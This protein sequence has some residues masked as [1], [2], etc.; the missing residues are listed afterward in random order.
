MAYVTEGGYPLSASI[1][2]SSISFNML[3]CLPPETLRQILQYLTYQDV[4]NLENIEQFEHIINRYKVFLPR[5]PKQFEI[6]CDESRLIY[7]FNS[8]DKTLLIPTMST[9]VVNDMIRCYSIET[10]KLHNINDTKHMVMMIDEIFPQMIKYRQKNIISLSLVGINVPKEKSDIWR[11]VFSCILKKDC[12]TLTFD[13]VTLS[14]IFDHQIFN[15]CKNIINV[16]WIITDSEE[17]EKLKCGDLVMS[18]FINHVRHSS[19]LKMKPLHAHMEMIT[20]KS[21][22]MFLDTWLNIS[23]PAPFNIVIEKCDD[24]WKEEFASECIISRLSN[25]NM[26]ISSNKSYFSH[27]K[28]SYDNNS[29]ITKITFSSIID[30]PAR[31]IHQ[32]MSHGRFYR[33]F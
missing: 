24:V 17:S 11:Y 12:K 32:R 6:F 26:Q 7:H 8:I 21:V 16:K 4:K 15:V 13:N 29:G 33:D 20:P 25:F 14:G 28:M 22:V 31:H 1:N 27:V 23:S 3:D 30:M 9:E 5:E 2:S 10:L 18:N 19:P